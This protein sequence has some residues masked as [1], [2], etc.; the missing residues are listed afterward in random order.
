[1]CGDGATRGIG[2][3]RGYDGDGG[4]MLRVRDSDGVAMMSFQIS[5][6][7]LDVRAP[8]RGFAGRFADVMMAE[9]RVAA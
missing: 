8:A 9:G 2:A 1:M 4:A 3:G 7:S 6:V 5:W